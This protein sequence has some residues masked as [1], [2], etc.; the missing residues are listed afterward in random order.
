MLIDETRGLAQLN[1]PEDHYLYA[2]KAIQAEVVDSN[3]VEPTWA[4][5]AQLG[6]GPTEELNV[7]RFGPGFWHES[8][9]Q[10]HSVLLNI[11][12]YYIL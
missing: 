5:A 12:N 1:E 2:A 7:P 9:M 8:N 11:Q 10:I 6:E 4:L 3:R